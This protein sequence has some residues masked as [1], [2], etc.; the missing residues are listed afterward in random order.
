MTH[1]GEAKIVTSTLDLVEIVEISSNQVI[2]IGYIDHHERMYKF[3]NFLPTSNEQD[4]LSH[5][6]ETSKLWHERFGHMN[7]KYLQALHKDEMVE[8]LPQI[9]SSN[10]ACIGC[11][12]GKHPERSYEKGK[13]MISSQ[14]IGLV[15]SDLIGALPTPSSGGS[16]YVLTFID[17]YL[18]FRWVYFLKL[19]SEVFEKLKIWKALVENQS[20]HRIKIIRTDNGK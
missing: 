19:K 17:D 4:L 8:G 10:G 5:A 6:N 13:K 1:T 9:K 15:H 16:R 20:V 12:V 14:P 2:A 7:Y 3:S 18:R 11:V